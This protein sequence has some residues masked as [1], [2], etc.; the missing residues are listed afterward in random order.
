MEIR[1]FFFM[2]FEIDLYDFNVTSV[3]FDISQASE[4][5]CNIRLTAGREIPYLQATMSYFVYCII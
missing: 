4:R 1:Q 2:P 5:E 3:Q